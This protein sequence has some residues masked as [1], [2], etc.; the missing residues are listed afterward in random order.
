M[1]D[2]DVGPWFM[3]CIFSCTSCVLERRRKEI[4]SKW[5][6]NEDRNVSHHHIILEIWLTFKTRPMLIF[7]THDSLKKAKGDKWADVLYFPVIYSLNH[8]SNLKISQIILRACNVYFFQNVNAINWKPSYPDRHRMD[9]AIKTKNKN[10][11]TRICFIW[12]YTYQ[13]NE[14]KKIKFTKM[15][16]YITDSS[17]QTIEKLFGIISVHK[18]K[19]R[20]YEQIS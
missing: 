14:K 6:W 13:L 12:V 5:Y 17:W 3:K 18:D 19:E 7:A 9:R 20:T 8:L 11:K 10:K 2:D 16:F 15:W 1:G 4:H